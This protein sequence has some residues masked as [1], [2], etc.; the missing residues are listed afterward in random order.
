LFPIADRHKRTRVTAPEAHPRIFSRHFR[1][2]AIGVL[3]VICNLAA[4]ASALAWGSAGHAIIAEIAEPRLSAAALAEVHQLLALKHQNHLAELSS[5]ADEHRFL[6]PETGPWHYVD[7]PLNASSYDAARDCPGDNCVV[8][9]IEEFTNILADKS[10]SPA[11][12]LE[13][14][15]Y[16]VHFVGDVHQPLHASNNDDAG[17]NKVQVIYLGQATAD[18]GYPWTLHSVW[19]TG[20]IEHHLA[21]AYDTQGRVDGVR[22]DVRSIARTLEGQLPLAKA[23]E[24]TEVGLDPV[25][26]AMEA[27]DLARTIAYHDILDNQ[28]KPL[29]QP[30]GIGTEYDAMAWIAIQLQMERAGVRLAAVLNAVLK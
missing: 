27:H 2:A 4:A 7:I 12:R 3:A 16:I 20:V 19:D 13:A 24:W 17:G 14:L 29:P 28:G 6:H 22:S 5:W 25:G 8:A 9:K 26:W 21:L 23:A 10:Q 15:E 30:I 18:E 11:T 1:S